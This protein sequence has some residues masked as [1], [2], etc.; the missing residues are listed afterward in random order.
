M[1]VAWNPLDPEFLADPY[2]T[3]AALRTSDRLHDTGF[4]PMVVTRYADVEAV[5]KNSELVAGAGTDEAQLD[6]INAIHAGAGL[7]PV[8]MDDKSLL[9]LDPPDHTRLRRLVQ[10]S[11]TPKA[12]ARQRDV[13]TE[14]VDGYCDRLTQAGPE[15]DLI[16]DY[17][18]PIPFA[19]ISR[20]LGLPGSDEGLVRDWSRDMTESLE[21]ILSDDQLR[22]AAV[23][24]QAMRD[25]LD[26]RVAEK[27]ADPGDDIIS[28]LIAVE[29]EGDRMDEKELVT[30][31]ILLFVAGHETTVNLIGNGTLALLR[32]PEQLARL[33]DSTDPA[34]DV[35]AIDEL[36]RYDSPVQTSGR[37]T[38][39]DVEVAGGIVPAGT[40]VVTSL[41]AANR[42]PEFWGDSADELDLGREGAG[43]HQSFGNGIHFCLGAALARTE[44]EIAITRLIRRFPELRLA[45]D[46]PEFSPRIVLRGMKA[47][48]VS[49][50]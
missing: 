45:T 38:V 12:I 15:V 18:F 19:I 40:P 33:R 50:V 46:Q 48:P 31:L 26:D 2:E 32:N 17:A 11:F 7:P 36:L 5:L 1:T 39:S 24:A 43:R 8:D 41:G 44:G 30:M 3:Y 28:E 21:P 9:G 47:L 16:A 13:V 23:A 6:H 29:E 20:L 35:N 49:L 4:G 14:V 22:D 37:N 27:R 34:F 10:K 42:D 25:Y